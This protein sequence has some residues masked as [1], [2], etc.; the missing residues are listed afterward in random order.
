MNATILT[1]SA[2]EPPSPPTAGEPDT[3]VRL[4]ERSIQLAPREGT[5]QRQ[6]GKLHYQ[7]KRHE[8]ARRHLEQAVALSP[9]DAD[10]WSLLVDLLNTV[11]DDAAMQRALATG[12]KH[13]PN[14][15]AL[16]FAN[17]SRL[18]RTGRV[19]EAI[20][21]LRQAQRLKPDEVRPSMELAS[22]FFRQDRVEEGMAEIRRAL[23]RRTGASPRLEHPHASRHRNRRRSPGP[24]QP[25]P[26][27]QSSPAA[28]GGP[29][30]LGGQLPQL[31]SVA[32]RGDRPPFSPAAP[33]PSLRSSLCPSSAWVSPLASRESTWAR[34]DDAPGAA[35]L[36]LVLM[37][38]AVAYGREA[39]P[40]AAARSLI[41]PAPPAARAMTF[42][43]AIRCT[44]GCPGTG[45]QSCAGGGPAC[46]RRARPGRA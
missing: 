19:G 42:P 23:G 2:S 4:L 14:S 12:L 6:L 28:T 29:R 7:L 15:A 20:G 40:G 39:A 37:V 9:E 24:A 1:G 30:H 45:G 27:P 38:G 17:G 33:C 25:V 5:Y 21:E 36:G 44:A 3:A 11:G 34:S 10:A 32:I 16:R 41:D 35:L 26:T 18:A 22:L 46:R 8:P 31:V 43:T 13:C